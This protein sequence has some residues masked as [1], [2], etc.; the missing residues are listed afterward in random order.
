M[1][2]K[3][4][5]VLLEAVAKLPSEVQEQLEVEIIGAGP[6]DAELT[7]KIGE[8]KLEKV[9][10]AVGRKDATYIRQALIGS[11]Y[12]NPSYS[13]EGLQTTLLEA[14]AMNSWI[15]TTPVSGYREV[16]PEGMGS[17]VAKESVD[18]LAQAL[19]SYVS[20]RPK[21]KTREHI[22]KHFSWES[23][24]SDYLHSLKK[25]LAK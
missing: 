9:V 7:K 15:I 5:L 6:E 4:W 21:G 2:A 16:L 11:A 12:V 18:D 3:G 24:A 8:L 1:R 10:K 25:A 13:S 14:A 22:V 20:N 23:I 19:T 17:V